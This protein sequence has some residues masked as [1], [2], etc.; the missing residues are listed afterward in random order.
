MILAWLH[1][2]VR[3]VG[4]AGSLANLQH[5][6]RCIEEVCTAEV[7]QST[8]PTSCSGIH[9]VV[10]CLIV[11]TTNDAELVVKAKSLPRGAVVIAR[12]S[13][14]ADCKR[15]LQCIVFVCSADQS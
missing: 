9:Q 3:I 15:E 8:A 6:F 12:L 14:R 1:V 2:F 4:I 7:A 13:L 11:L 10:Y 5:C